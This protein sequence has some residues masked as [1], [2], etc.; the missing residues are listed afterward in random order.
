MKSYL[1]RAFFVASFSLS[2]AAS[3]T[4]AAGT[5]SRI[6]NLSTRGMVGSGADVLIAGFVIGGT[7]PKEVLI[8]AVGP[9]LADAGVKEVLARPRL[10]VY[11]R[12]GTVIATQESW[13]GTLKTVFSQIG[14]LPLPDGSDDA[15]I[16]L[17]LDPGAY[18]VHVSGVSAPRGV[19]L[20]EIYELGG[21]SRLLNL[22]TRGRVE[23]GEKLMIS[24]LVISGTSPRRV[25]LRAGGPALMN[26][27]VTGVLPDPKLSLIDRSGKVVA[28]N[29]DWCDSDYLE[30]VIAAGTNA[31]AYAFKRS[32]Y[33]SA[34]LIDL[35][36]GLYTMHVVGLGDR[37]GIALLEVYDL[38]D[39]VPAGS[40]ATMN[41][42]AAKPNPVGPRPKPNPKPAPEPTA[43]P[44]PGPFTPYSTAALS[45]SWAD[46]NA[47]LGPTFAALNPGAIDDRPTLFTNVSKNA[48]SAYYVRIN[49]YELGELGTES[50][51]WSDTG[52]VGYIPNDPT[53]DPGLDRVQFFAYYNR[54]FAI[55]PRP[56]GASGQL[57]S[58]PQ[59][60][61]P[62][63]IELNGGTPM[64]PVAMVRG[65]GMQQNE[66]VM[67]YRDGLFAVAGMQ[68]SRSGSERPYPGFKFPKHKV[69]RGIAITT[70]NEF[71]LV[72]IWDTE[73]NQ[74]QLAV[75][76]LE[77]K[78]LPFHTWPYMGM[79][80]QGSFSDFKLLG[81]IDLPMKSPEA[82]AAASNG[83][84]RGPS[85]TD[86]SVLSQIDLST[87]GDRA[88]L[89]NG[90][91]QFVVAK[92]GYAIVSS[93][94]DNK[95]VVVDLTPLFSYMRES[96]LSSL[97][98][99]HKTLAAR[100]PGP[101]QFPQT[102]DVNPAI[103]PVIV[104]QASVNQPT[105]VLAGQDVDR[106]SKDRFKAYIACREGLVR[107]IDT[108][109]MMARY[110][111]EI[112]G[113]LKEIGTVTVGRNPV[114]MAFARHGENG[115]PLIPLDTTGVQRA[116]DA[117]N[118]MF[119]V[120]CRGERSID[121]VVTWHG[122]GQV[123]RRIKDTRLGDPVAVSVA[124]RG[125]IVTAADFAGKKLVSFRIG[126]IRDTR[127]N[128]VYPPGDP[129]YNYEFAGEMPLLG[130][131]F[132][133]NSANLN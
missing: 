128:K 131:P 111:W 129:N 9:T 42:T 96:Y 25:L 32:S 58:D 29:D 46:V 125:N 31:G 107:I 26:V 123:Y 75:V 60:R 114:G 88:L 103:K 95:A 98:S 8:R 82:V 106:W 35:P 63:Y 121:A 55:S 100:G 69:P 64:Q 77:A 24:G 85:S 38:T 22:S 30:D 39:T 23:T 127:N 28:T 49:P 13:P 66:Q 15:A 70:S 81:Y 16:R 97:E 34:L 86:N 89:Y 94:E 76:A 48:G 133:V 119:Y 92:N 43:D 41:S 126:T 44:T 61:E 72:T 51:Y 132:L 53:A 80:N 56:D 45:W 71:A 99:F 104:W 4:H 20:A 83:L 59:T 115:L 113:E 79:P 110:T 118:N 73:R 102:F 50:D 116:P 68:T 37:P 5:D 12:Q 105:A 10:T 57:H 90:G 87:E 62:R 67:V 40:I 93:L 14:A 84:W 52:Q 6:V 91:W 120:A 11:N 3:P 130:S 122:Q 36:P 27:G 17:T 18:S 74:G 21:T 7:E 2:L 19:A 124:V 54:V 65:Y 108:S 117:K 33:D 101:A 1:I 78:F 47:R 109:S 112:R